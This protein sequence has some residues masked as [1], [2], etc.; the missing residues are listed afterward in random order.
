MYGVF[1]TEAE[2]ENKIRNYPHS[3]K[4]SFNSHVIGIHQ[5]VIEKS[6]FI[7]RCFYSDRKELHS[8]RGIYA[9]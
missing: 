7:L 5:Y 3:K 9:S 4:H 2:T 1:Y 8:I 6:R